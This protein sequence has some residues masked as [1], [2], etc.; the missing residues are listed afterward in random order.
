MSFQ[1]LILDIVMALF[2]PFAGSRLFLWLLR[3]RLSER[4][5][6]LLA[7]LSS[8]LL[9]VVVLGGLGWT[10]P[11]TGNIPI[12]IGQIGWLLWDLYRRRAVEAPG[13]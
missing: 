9:L 4:R 3:G 11:N 8:W 6:L 10:T 5:R 1:G 12:T 2:W 7:H 13:A